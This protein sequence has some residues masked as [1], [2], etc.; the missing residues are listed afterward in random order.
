MSEIPT[1]TYD[2]VTLGSGEATKVLAWKVGP[3]S[4][5]HLK[6]AT[7]ERK[8]R[9][10]SCP[11]V[12]CLPSKNVIYSADAVH[13]ARQGTF[14]LKA[15]TA[16]EIPVDMAAV[17]Q[18]KDKMVKGLMETHVSNYNASGAE[19]IWG[20]GTFVGPK[21]IEVDLN[22]GGKLRVKAETIVIGTGSTALVDKRIP[23]LGESGP[24]THIEWLDLESLP[25]HLILLGGGYVGLEMAQASARLGSR[26][27]IVE[28]GPRILKQEDEDVTSAIADVLIG[29]GVEILAGWEVVK[30]EGKS[31]EAVKVTVKD[32]SSGTVKVLDGSHILAS[33]GRVPN[34]TGIGLDVA[35]VE[36]L[37]NGFIKVDE[38]LRTTAPGVF[39]VGDCAG[40]PMFTHIGYDDFRIV[41]SVITNSPNK[42]S[43]KDRQVP[44]CLF[45]DPQIAHVGLREHEAK[46]KGIPYRLAKL[47]MAAFLR[48]RTIQ[49]KSV[50]FT[51]ALIEPAPGQ[52]ILGFTAMGPDAGELL[53]LVQLVMKKGLP[54]TEIDDLIIT[55]PTMVE[56]VGFLFAAVPA[57]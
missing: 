46:A 28:R 34:T 10:G 9:G 1:V 38:F 15:I 44:S 17:K 51:K 55:H 14:G 42:F 24:L 36:V 26:V 29:E 16:Q 7:I 50:G 18:R 27:T 19:M 21:E 48:T 39:A 45:T 40:S 13:K 56:G 5:S 53:P 8:W 4:P 43:T 31:G 41:R 54:Y 6:T 47:P 12:A 11:N 57:E 20:N 23:G 22:D 49:D 32:K 35:G 33:A 52:K 30:V 2:L 37:S 25:S 3:N